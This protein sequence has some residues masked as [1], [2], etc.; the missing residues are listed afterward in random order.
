MEVYVYDITKNTAVNRWW[1]SETK[2]ELYASPS[3]AFQGEI[4]YTEGYVDRH[5]PVRENFLKE[6]YISEVT[7]QD[8]KQEEMQELYFPFEN[9]RVEDTRFYH[10]PKYISF[11]GHTY[12]YVDEDCL[13]NFDLYTCGGIKLWLEDRLITCF[14]PYTRNRTSRKRL[15]L[16]LVKGLNRLSIY[17]DD[18]AERDVL[19]Q[20]ELR[21][22]GEEALTGILQLDEDVKE[23]IIAE[24]FLSTCYFKNEVY[25]EGNISMSCNQ[26]ILSDPIQADIE[27]FI[28]EKQLVNSKKV[29]LNPRSKAIVIGKVEEWSVGYY[30]I[31]VCLKLKTVKIQREFTI[32]VYPRSLMNLPLGNSIAYRKKE[33]LKRIADDPKHDNNNILPVLAVEKKL[34]KVAEVLLD[35]NLRKI[36]AL[37]DN[38]V[39]YVGLMLIVLDKFAD[40]IGPDYC[41][42]IQKALLGFRY[43]IDEPGNDVMWYFSET[44]ALHFHVAQFLTGSMLSDKKFTR[45]GHLGKQVQ[46]LGRKRLLAW[47][48]HFFKNGY[49]DWSAISHMPTNILGFLYLYELTDDIEIRNAAI[50]CLDFTFKQITYH[51]YKG[52]L[53]STFGRVYERQLKFREM[54]DVPYLTWINNGEGYINN[55]TRVVSVYAYSLYQPEN[56][57]FEVEASGDEGVIIELNQGFQSRAIYSFKTEDYMISSVQNFPAYVRGHQ[58]HIMNIAL[59]KGVQCFI[60]HPGEKTVYGTGRPSY[61]AGN[62]FTPMIR[63][64]KN[65]ALMHYIIPEEAMVHYVHLYIPE[66]RFDEVIVTDQDVIGRIDDTYMAVKFSH[67]IRRQ[68][69]GPTKE[70]EIIC[71]GRQHLIY[72]KCSS[73]KQWKSF[74]AFVETMKNL[75]TEYSLS[76]DFRVL[77]P[78]FGLGEMDRQGGLQVGNIPVP[79]YLDNEVMIERTSLKE[80]NV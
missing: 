80:I 32:G 56:V 74:N 49:A 36:E 23:I 45:S 46:K 57:S 50:Q 31:I 37:E 51:T 35:E 69:M 21:Y 8:L 22:L 43:W 61:W 1:L 20:F 64:Y 18:L 11:Y 67:P 38:S 52:L 39:T 24:K 26:G 4:N 70:K 76:G 42:R 6:Q 30:K 78:E 75:A 2:A 44:H 9:A 33:T 62:G 79:I 65:M 41:Q 40:I 14:T 47:F 10:K 15:H 59:G 66:S 63:Q 19:F 17:M 60:N 58:Q 25:S 48:E 7:Y 12:L 68:N 28:N 34:T 54:T 13:M 73:K 53:S 27:C 3:K 29:D 5:Y 55:S 71:H 77:D 16:P 72:V